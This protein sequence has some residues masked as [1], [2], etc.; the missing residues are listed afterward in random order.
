MKSAVIKFLK[1]FVPIAI[2]VYLTWYFI[3]GLDQKQID[4]T[5]NAFYDANYFWVIL[6][7]IVAFLSHLSRAYRWLFLLE[8]LG[9]KPKLSNAYHAVMSGYVINFTVPRSGEFAR[10]GLLSTYEKVPFEKGFATIVIERVID[11][12]ML[13]LVVFI[14][15]LLQ[16]NSEEFEQITQ[17]DS[18]SGSHLIWYILGAGLLFGAVG[19]IVFLK[20]EKFKKFVVEKIKGFYEGLKSIWTMKKKWAFVFHTVF[21]WA[22]YVAGI[23]IFAQAFEETAGMSIGCVF[24]A[25]VVGAAAIALLPGGLGAY[26]AWITAVLA[27][28]G[29]DFAAYGIF[30]WSVQTILLVVLGLISLFLIQRKPKVLE[31]NGQ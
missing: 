18:A 20:N 9:Y 16:A 27:L 25:F 14:T 3:S 13:G 8:P 11:V 24:G 30:M 12:L 17:A 19:L 28:Y 1:I 5:K 22:C 7:L 26:P 15:G 4:Q 21:I 23:W 31:S 10:A 2:G 6:S 29:M